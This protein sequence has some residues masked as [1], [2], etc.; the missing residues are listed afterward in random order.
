METGYRRNRVAAGILAL[1]FGTLGIH[2]FYLGRTS[3]AIIQLLLTIVGSLLFGVGIVI[4]FIWS[5]IEAILI[6]MGK[7][8]DGDGNPTV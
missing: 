8:D 2:N 1:L 6:F 4:S 7:L 3:V 5:F